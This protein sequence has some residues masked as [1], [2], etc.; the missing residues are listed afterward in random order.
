MTRK[1]YSSD[2]TDAEWQLVEPLIPSAQAGEGSAS[3]FRRE[4]VNAIFYVWRTSCPWE[5]LPDDLPHHSTVC[6]YFRRWQKEGVWQQM[7]D[8]LEKREP[9][10]A[11]R[12]PEASANFIGGQSVKTTKP[13]NVTVIEQSFAHV[14]PRSTEF[15]SSFYKN[16]FTDYPQLRQLFAHTTMQFQEQKLMMSLVLV[17]NN[18]RNL[19]YLKILLRDLGERHVRYGARRENYPMVGATLL[20][21]LESYLG[22]D[23]TPE[24]KQAWTDAYEAIADLMLEGENSYEEGSYAEGRGQKDYNTL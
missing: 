17:L 2:L 19:T 16:L 23:W 10:G 12:K 20:K 1:S 22:A 24:V 8:C 13:L 18:L 21:T 6:F 3:D 4:I 9:V 5:K 11:E 14:K 7:K 15:A